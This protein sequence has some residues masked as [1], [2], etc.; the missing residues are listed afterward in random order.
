LSEYHPCIEESGPGGA[1]DW[2]LQLTVN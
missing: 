1:Y 2:I